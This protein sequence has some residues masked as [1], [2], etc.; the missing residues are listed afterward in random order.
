[1]NLK[2]L[3]AAFPVILIL[4]VSGCEVADRGRPAGALSIS[5]LMINPQYGENIKIYGKVN[6]LGELQCPCF[7]L[8]SGGKEI[9]VWYDLMSEGG[10]DWPT[11]DTSGIENGDWVVVSGELKK[12]SPG[13]VVFWALKI[14]ETE[15]LD[16]EFSSGADCKFSCMES[17]YA[18]GVCIPAED[19]EPFAIEI[20]DCRIP[21]SDR[22]MDKNQCNCY[23]AG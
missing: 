5:E 13:K 21:A 2:G 18:E 4:L 14:K 20:G 16:I 1:M 9:E 7:T 8:I 17:G 3:L 10:K 6:L 12:Q 11:A 22:C 15:S 19:R 23:C